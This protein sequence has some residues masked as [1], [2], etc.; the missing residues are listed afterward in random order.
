MAM[1]EAE[2]PQAERI[3]VR[4]LNEGTEV[5]RPTMGRPVSPGTF[6][7]LATSDFETAS[8]EWEFAPGTHV[9]CTWPRLSD[10]PALVAVRPAPATDREE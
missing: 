2:T 6:E 8:E 7:V 4:L 9:L 1:R 3:Y 10:G 5:W